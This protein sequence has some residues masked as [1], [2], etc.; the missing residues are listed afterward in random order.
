MNKV[1]KI[2]KRRTLINLKHLKTN[3]EIIFIEDSSYKVLCDLDFLNKYLI[4]VSLTDGLILAG[5][6]IVVYQ[7][8]THVVYD[9]IGTAMHNMCSLATF[10]RLKHGDEWPDMSIS[11]TLPM[12]TRQFAAQIYSCNFQ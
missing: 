12:E 10:F 6:T 5:N 2:I 1:T 7:T 4:C 8:L 9:K 3:F 11:S